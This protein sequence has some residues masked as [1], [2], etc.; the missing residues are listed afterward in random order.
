VLSWPFFGGSLCPAARLCARRRDYC[1][2]RGHGADCGN[3]RDRPTDPR[4]RGAGGAYLTE[5]L[6]PVRLRHVFG[7]FPTGVAA[8][9]ALVDDGPQRDR[10]QFVHIR[11]PGP[12]HGAGRRGPRIDY[13]AAAGKRGSGQCAV[14]G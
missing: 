2:D 12:G 10:R 9:A 5:W 7:P 6:E 3:R 14:S 4:R 13:L 11:L 8:L 1:V